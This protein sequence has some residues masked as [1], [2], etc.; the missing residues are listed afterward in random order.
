M[1]I[2]FFPTLLIRHRKISLISTIDVIE[3][4]IIRVLYN[5]FAFICCRY[6]HI[7]RALKEAIG[8]LILQPRALRR[9]RVS[10]NNI[11][12]FKSPRWPSKLLIILE[13]QTFLNKEIK[14][15]SDI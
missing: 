3:M 4:E 11:L 13:L 9:S 15:F 10:I 7:Q 8:R 1:H 14:L 2:K 5:W 6:S 12:E